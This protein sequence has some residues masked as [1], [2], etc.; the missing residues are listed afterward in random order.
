MPSEI[1]KQVDALMHRLYR[2]S[3]GQMIQPL[4]ATYAV[5]DQW[6][7]HLQP[8]YAVSDRAIVRMAESSWKMLLPLGFAT[9]LRLNF[10]IW[11]FVGL[12]LLVRQCL[13]MQEQLFSGERN[14]KILLLRTG[15]SNEP[16][17]AGW[18]S[19]KHGGEAVSMLAINEQ[20]GAKVAALRHLPGLIYHYAG[21]ARAL[22]GSILE[23]QRNG[24]MNDAICRV[25][26]PV[27]LVLL[28]RTAPKM[29]IYRRWAELYLQPQ[30]QLTHL[31]FTMNSMLEA[32][33]M[34][35]LPDIQHAYVEHGFP[36]RDIPPLACKQYVYGKQYADYLRAFDATIEIEELGIDYFPKTEIGEKQRTIVVASLQDWPQWG[37]SRV[38]DRFNAAL[39]MAK[40]QGWRVVFRGRNYDEDAF[41]RGLQCGWDEMSIPK[42][43]TFAECLSRLK[44][45]MVW[46]SWSTAVLDAEAMGVKGVCFI[47]SSLYDYFIPAFGSST[48]AVSSEEDL[49]CIP[50]T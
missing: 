16:N 50:L 23:M 8:D 34:A 24:E 48:I 4:L 28:A 14:R 25:L 6:R 41:A 18:L 31:Y 2:Y 17:I 21:L 3:A 33:F 30:S 37:I 7:H 40:A 44:P 43:E 49:K 36:R 11:F 9:A 10:M 19:D 5:A 38:A 20:A 12:P 26:P 39:A 46:T 45:A 47:D 22:T 27:W 1:T 35:A 32:S 13:R 42:Q 15:V 29:C